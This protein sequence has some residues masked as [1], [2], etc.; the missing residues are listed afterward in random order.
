MKNFS[1]YQVININNFSSF[2]E[3]E[4]LFFFSSVKVEGKEHNFDKFH[5]RPIFS[6]HVPSSV[7]N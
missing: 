1:A 2:E 5:Y 4:M 7:T 3:L 6:V